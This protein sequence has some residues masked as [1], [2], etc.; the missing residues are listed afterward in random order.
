MTDI[1][2]ATG[3]PG[4]FAQVQKIFAHHGIKLMSPADFGV[5]IDVE[6]IG[7]TLEQNATLKAQAY[8]KIL[9]PHTII[10]GDDTG[11]EIDALGGEPGIMVRRWKGSHMEDEEI[12]NYCLDKLAG[13][14]VAKRGAQFRTVLAVAI[15][16]QPVQYFEGI[17]R[18]V[19][20]EKPMEGR[21]IGMPFWPIFYLPDLQMTLGEFHSEPMDFQLAHP[22][23]RERAVMA[24]LPYL[25]AQ[26]DLATSTN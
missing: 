5:K 1:V 11:I 7:K 15:D 13:V 14:P 8:L 26:A 6:E 9:P 22:T 21:E 3:N 23:H 4:K 18:G 16:E 17:M 24:A 25:T 2:Y 10:I 12:I 19:I 20:L